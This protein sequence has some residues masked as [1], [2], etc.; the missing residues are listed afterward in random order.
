[1]DFRKNPNYYYPGEF[2][3]SKYIC[4]TCRKVFKRKVLS[5]FSKKT[6]E[7]EPKCPQ[8]GV[9]TTWIG[10]K[11]RAP[12]GDNIQAWNSIGVLAN[13][14]ALNFTGFA[15]YRIQIPETTKALKDMLI[16]IKENYEFQINKYVS[17]DY[18]E[19]NK[20]Q[21]GYFSKTIKKINLHLNTITKEKKSKIESK[22]LNKIVGSVKLPKKFNE[23]KEL[24]SYYENKHL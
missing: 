6:D 20:K 19:N 7:K 22:K 14:G 2:Y 10:L 18:N 8:C 15:T 13:I 21:I 4:V 24:S 16:A 9:L 5:D 23:K 12:K 1:M 3:K 17:S 11:F